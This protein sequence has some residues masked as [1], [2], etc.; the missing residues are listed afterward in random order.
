MA[1]HTLIS[2]TQS[3][4]DTAAFLYR[5]RLHMPIAL[6]G[7][8]NK[9]CFA[10]IFLNLSLFQ[11]SYSQDE[12]SQWWLLKRTKL[13]P[14]LTG[15]SRH[16]IEYLTGS[17]PT[18]LHPILNRPWSQAECMESEEWKYI[19]DE[20]SKFVKAKYEEIGETQFEE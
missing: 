11:A 5:D 19:S 8:M 3:S 17:I 15:E 4:Y 18:L 1:R 12:M 2:C 16:R 20:V 10:H 7:G 14:D 13:P 6:M 9:V